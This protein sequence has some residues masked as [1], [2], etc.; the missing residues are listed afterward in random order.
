[1]TTLA[2]V[3]AGHGLG[4]AVAR[5]F[6]TEGFSVAVLSRRQ[7]RVD[8]LANDLAAVGVTARGYAANVRDPDALTSALDRAADDLGPIEVLQYSPVPQAEFMQPVLDTTVADLTGAIE[9]S[10]YGPLTAL[11]H[12]LP[13]M[14]T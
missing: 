8:A 2:I 12:V 6:S 1:M 11:R 14:R 13:G 10:I 3:G 5:R 9:F 4:A 7:D